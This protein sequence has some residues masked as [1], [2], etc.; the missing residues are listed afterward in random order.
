MSSHELE[1]TC[2]NIEDDEDEDY[3]SN[4]E[5]AIESAFFISTLQSPVSNPHNTIGHK[6]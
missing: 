4:I 2:G 3:E 5:S 6:G 1:M